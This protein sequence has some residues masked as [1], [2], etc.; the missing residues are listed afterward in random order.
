MRQG[1]IVEVGEKRGLLAAPRH[2]YTA[3]ADR[4]PSL[5]A[6]GRRDAA[7]RR[8]ASRRGAAPLLD[9]EDLQVRFRQ[10]RTVQPELPSIRRSNGV[11]LRVMPGETVGIVGE[12]GSGK[13]T[14]A[15]AIL[16]LTPI[17]SGHVTLRGRRLAPRPRRGWRT[18][19]Q[20]RRRW[21]SRTR[22]N[23]LNPRMTIGQTLAEVL[24][25][26]GKHRAR[27]TSPARSASC[28]TSSGSTAPSLDRKPRSMSGGQCQRAGIARALAVDPRLIIADE[29]VAALD[30]TIQAQI[31]ELFR[32]LRG[33]HAPDAA[34]HRPRP[35]HRAQSLRAR[36]GDASRRDRR[37]G[38]VGGDF[39]PAPASLHCRA[40]RRDP[41]TSTR[42]SR[43]LL[44]RR[45]RP[46]I[47][48]RSRTDH[49]KPTRRGM[50]D[51]EEQVD[52]AS[53]SPRFLAGLT[54]GAG[55]A[56]AA[57]V[58]TIGRREDFD[59]LR[60]DQD[61]AE[62]RLLGVLQRLR[63]ADP[64]RQDRHQAGARPGRELGRS[65]DDGLTYTLQACATPSSPTARRSPPRTPPSRLLRI[66][67]DEGSLWADQLQRHRHRRGDRRPHAR[68]QAEA[69]RSAPFLSTLAMP[70]ASILSKA[71]LETLG[72]GG[73]RREPRR[74]PAPSPSRSGGAATASSWRRTRI[75]GRPTESASTA[76]SGSRCPTTTPAC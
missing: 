36:R 12:S 38:S 69:R 14:L 11:S 45:W 21:C 41:A 1:R 25:V 62:H 13:S 27:A 56:E 35:R 17:T 64:R 24:R 63:R 7:V 22:Y 23:A 39:R 43:C 58:L 31:V 3:L 48:M 37:G 53:A 71:G 74:A 6:G 44:R 66:R 26:Q 72:D 20:R 34:V 52:A 57:G 47:P 73:L 4:Q 40:D 61:R 70:G 60:P 51:V 49:Q 15:R 76:S 10:R 42:T 28:S 16:G 2:P 30:V 29:C 59:H 19:R 18:L 50:H 32:D 5:A 8:S 75:S 67:D 55:I 68:R 46:R 9:I 33:A 65:S 54:I